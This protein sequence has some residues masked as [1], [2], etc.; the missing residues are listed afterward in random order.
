MS[1]ITTFETISSR[2]L[3]EYSTTL[4]TQSGSSG[5]TSQNDKGSAGGGGGEDGRGEGKTAR[6]LRVRRTPRASHHS[7][8]GRRAERPRPPADRPAK[9]S[10]RVRVKLTIARTGAAQERLVL[11]SRGPRGWAVTGAIFGCSAILHQS[12]PIQAGPTATRA[13]HPRR[14]RSR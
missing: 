2:Q 9:H 13:Q 4:T 5:T 10:A 14:A 6:Q 11:C 12:R 7:V 3:W 8:A 1:R